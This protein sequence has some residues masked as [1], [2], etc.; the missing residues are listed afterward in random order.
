ML[1]TV[2]HTLPDVE[3]P[4][5]TG[6]TINPRRVQGEFI[7]FCYPWTGRPSL[8]NPP[9]WDAIAGA[10]GSTPQALSYGL[11]HARFALHGVRI[12]G[13]SLQSTDY[14]KEFEARNA[15]PF[16][17]LSDSERQFSTPLALPVFETGGVIYLSRVTLFARD[18][19]I[20][21]MRY[22]VPDPAGDAAAM[23]D[24]VQSR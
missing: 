12:F 6:E 2:G 7:I 17:L 20:R 14:Q 5:T 4:A 24:W 19:V 11:L 23:F 13:L 9:D 8:P 21:H 18:G 10:H 16:A 15:L 1:A 22:P 3:L